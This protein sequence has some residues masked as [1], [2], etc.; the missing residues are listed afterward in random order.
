MKANHPDILR[1]L[2]IK[3]SPKS[4]D[5][6]K[7]KKPFQLHTLLTEQRHPH[8]W[9]LSFNIKDNVEKGLR[10]ILCVDQ[11]I[12]RTFHRLAEDTSLLEQAAGAVSRAVKEGRKI[13]I[14]GCGSTGRL[15]KQMESSLWR[16]FWRKA[17]KSPLWDKL[18]YALTEAIEDRLIGEMT[19]GDRALISAL[20]GFEDLQ[21]VG[22]LQLKERRVERGDVVFCITEGG[23]T[24]SVIGAVRAAC[25]EYG[26]LDKDSIEDA[27]KHL[28]F[29][30]NNPHEVLKPLERSRSV[31]DNPAITKINLSTGPQAVAGST[32]MQAATSETY[33]MGA[34][35]EAGIQ[36]MLKEILS[37]EEMAQLGF[38]INKSIKETL[39]SF[40]DVR[41]RILD[42]L[43]NLREFV[44]LESET[45]R[46]GK[47]STY[48]AKKALITVFIDCAERSP[49][50]HLY[51]L[52]TV[53]Q[54]NRKCWWQVWTE[55]G[56]YKEA[57]QNFL[58]REFRGLDNS[59]YEH[60]FLSQIED[61][62]LKE[63]ALRSL[64]RAGSDQEKLFDF[65]FSRENTERRGPQQG[66]LGVVVFQDEEI[67]DL[68]RSDSSPAKF[69]SLFKEKKADVALISVSDKAP[70]EVE[71]IISPLPLKQDQD[72]V[73]SIFMK[74]KGDP[75]G[76][77][78]QTALKMLLNAHSSAV[79]ARMGRMVGNTMTNVHPSNL[80]LIGRATYLI[81]SHVN[82]TIM[83]KE[84]IKKNGKSDPLTY[85][86][87]NAVLFEAMDFAAARGEQT[88]EVEISIIRI[89]E[90]LRK[91]SFI[92]WQQALSVSETSGLENYLEKHNSALRRK[93]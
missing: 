81:M 33:V 38:S 13:F 90:A 65:S 14:Y 78:R 55:A 26:A 45:Y 72:V 85:S 71:N 61:S 24:S 46:K 59:F 63:A 60:H 11:D 93:L 21:L 74:L 23:E 9:S 34:I 87:A 12:S 79:M 57:W 58:G 1:L 2:K 53:K 48:F 6:V 30:Y 28:Y 62:Y 80:K 39:L 20:E 36:K 47:R 44:H 49:T 31:L 89:L 17:K 66:D 8:T 27:K 77:K 52:D 91:K 88:S 18:K 10:Q 51:P 3:P 16:P 68:A 69:I 56:N 86:Q 84:W 76:L 40:D 82:D 73:I 70:E 5:Y 50:F 15:A 19:G 43:K 35:L 54:K 64:S 37:G 42:S 41:K 25:E 7:N 32:R 75:L 83:Q 4:M 29:L 67:D 22:K 92:S